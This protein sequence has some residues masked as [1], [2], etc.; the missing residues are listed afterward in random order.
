ME[1][2][3]FKSLGLSSGKAIIRLMYRDPKQFKIQAHVSTP[4]L[5]KSVLTVD[6]ASKNRNPQRMPSP[7][8]HCSK[9]TERERDDVTLSV[10]IVPNTESQNKL[11]DEANMDVSVDE[12]KMDTTDETRPG[13]NADGE[14][15][16]EDGQT[17]MREKGKNQKMNT[18][19]IKGTHSIASNVKD[20]DTERGQNVTEACKRDQEN[21]YKI[22]FVRCNCAY[23]QSRSN[24]V[25]AY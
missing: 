1:K 10:N 3:T 4:L 17:N 19:A 12:V 13:A 16:V 6:D 14:M 7:T 8:P 9:T 2:T 25:F 11:E 23:V 20:Y 18:S 5:P 21:T 24:D 22:E 15:D